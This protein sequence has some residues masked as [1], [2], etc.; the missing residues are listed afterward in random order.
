MARRGLYNYNDPQLD[1]YDARDPK[2]DKKI[3]KDYINQITY[4]ISVIRE[5]ANELNDILHVIPNPHEH[6]NRY[7]QKRNWSDS[8]Y[9]DKINKV[10]AGLGA[11]DVKF[12]VE[13]F[14]AL[15]EANWGL[16]N[17]I[18][19]IFGNRMGVREVN[20]V[21]NAPENQLSDIPAQDSN[22][23]MYEYRFH[24]IKQNCDKVNR[25]LNNIW[26]S[27]FDGN[28][29]C[30]VRCQVACQE[31]CQLGCQSCQYNTCHDQNCGGFS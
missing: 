19:N 9:G 25:Y 7:R 15:S 11:Y 24:I 2:N 6:T 3:T 21:N 27:Y 10:N 22:S 28:G 29:Y 18:I 1:I 14:R 13:G 8:Y 4:I 17:H 30:R 16:I 5:Q 26:G 23:K 12:T 20:D 31:A